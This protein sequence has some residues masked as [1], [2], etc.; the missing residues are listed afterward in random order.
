MEVTEVKL[1][2]NGVKSKSFDTIIGK[3]FV[4]RGIAALP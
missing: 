4:Q 2:Q 3:G 1:K